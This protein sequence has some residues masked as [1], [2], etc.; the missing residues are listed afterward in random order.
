MGRNQGECIRRVETHGPNVL[1]KRRALAGAFGKGAGHGGP[2]EWMS[3][4]R[5]ESPGRSVTPCHMPCAHAA[6]RPHPPTGKAVLNGHLGRR[7]PASP[8]VRPC[9]LSRLQQLEWTQ[10]QLKG[11]EFNHQRNSLL[12][13]TM[14]RKRWPTVALRGP[15][16]G[17]RDARTSSQNHQPWLLPSL[18][19]TAPGDHVSVQRLLLAMTLAYLGLALHQHD[20][21]D[22]G[23]LQASR[24][25]RE[26]SCAERPCGSRGALQ[27]GS[28]VGR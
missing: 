2:H 9:W 18:D 5:E 7:R 28:G 23:S 19:R 16:R 20:V 3:A 26:L 4:L 13:N 27:E 8:A 22:D 6:R 25:L 17:H 10:T 24:G 14:P 1:P 11:F 15:A 12:E 21:G